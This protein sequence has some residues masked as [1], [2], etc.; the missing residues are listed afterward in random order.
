MPTKI[1][2]WHIS[3]NLYLSTCWE[4]VQERTT[5]TIFTKSMQYLSTYSCRRIRSWD[6]RAY[7]CRSPSIIRYFLCSFSNSTSV[8]S[9]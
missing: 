5:L 2:V 3:A 4:L 6:S 9:Q 7:A 1:L 8:E